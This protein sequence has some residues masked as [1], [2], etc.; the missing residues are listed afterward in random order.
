MQNFALVLTNLKKLIASFFID[1]IYIKLLESG[2]NL[3]KVCFICNKKINQ[4]CCICR[5]CS[6]ESTC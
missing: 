4:I 1:N 5:T 2:G 6:A 3:L